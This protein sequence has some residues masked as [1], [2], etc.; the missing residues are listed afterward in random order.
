[1]KLCLIQLYLCFLLISFCSIF[2]DMM[3]PCSIRT[4]IQMK[5]RATLQLV[6]VQE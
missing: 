5:D 2:Q 3:N 1:M 6:Q 4:S